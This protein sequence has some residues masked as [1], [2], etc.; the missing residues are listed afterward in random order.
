[1][2]WI[3]H[4]NNRR[5]SSPS[6]AIGPNRSVFQLW[7]QR[8]Q[9]VREMDLQP[10]GLLQSI[11]MKF[12]CVDKSR[13]VRTGLWHPASKKFDWFGNCSI[14]FDYRIQLNQ[15]L[16]RGWTT[17]MSFWLNSISDRHKVEV[18]RTSVRL[19]LSFLHGL[20]SYDYRNNVNMLKS[21][22]QNHSPATLGYTWLLNILTLFLCSVREPTKNIVFD[23]FYNNIGSCWNPFRF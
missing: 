23:Y 8:G 22:Q 7:R 18:D 3:L 2:S 17:L 20:Y 6:K 11:R 15:R 12:H 13:S 4:L 1:M 21:L 9:V 5:S 14:L 16:M 19:L 10:K